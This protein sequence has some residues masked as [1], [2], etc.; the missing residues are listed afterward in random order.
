MEMESG[1]SC[2]EFGGKTQ[3]K[4][5]VK[6]IQNGLTAPEKYIFACNSKMSIIS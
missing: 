5:K 4:H 1:V 6:E 2:K 3:N